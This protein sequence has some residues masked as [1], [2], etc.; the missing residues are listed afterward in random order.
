MDK[1]N[2]LNNSIIIDS[3]LDLLF[4]LVR[5]RKYG[6]KKVLIEDYLEDFK[7]GGVNVIVSSIYLDG[8]FLPEMALRRALKQI[9]S[10]YEEIE[11]SKDSFALCLSY[12]DIINTINDGKIAILLSFEGVEPLYNDI[13]LLNVFYKLGVRLVGLTW[14]RRNFAGDGCYFGTIKEGK[15]GGLTEFGVSL[16]EK[17]EELGMLI[18]V[19]HLNDEGFWDVIE[20]SNQPVIASHS[21]SRA[22]VNIMRNLTDEQIKAIAKAGGIIGINCANILVSDETDSKANIKGYVDHIEH[23]ANLVGH[24]YV[25]F[26]FDL[27]DKIMKYVAEEELKGI[28][29]K[30]FDSIK[31]YADIP[32][33]IE[34]MQRRNFSQEQITDILGNNF[35]EIFKKVLK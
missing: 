15:K 10:L 7:K 4:D 6:R 1:K 21:N 26:G 5:Q 22:L 23:I 30:S 3:H 28:S 8:E 27:C 17:A 29:R 13:S 16:I 25:G 33:I 35:M 2:I 20:Y 14:S 18:D 12:N 9:N 24:K 34:E 31:G 19:T 11:E 32:N